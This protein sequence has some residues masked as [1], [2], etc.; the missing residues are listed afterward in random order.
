MEVHGVQW[1]IMKC[2]SPQDSVVAAMY[3]STGQ[4]QKTAQEVLTTLKEHPDAW[5]KVGEGGIKTTHG[6]RTPHQAS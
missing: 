2:T 1:R 5:T 3:A 4:E 6:A